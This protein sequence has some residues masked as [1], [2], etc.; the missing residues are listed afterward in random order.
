MNWYKKAQGNLRFENNHIDSHHRQNDYNLLAKINDKSVGM[1]EYSEY[2]DEIYVNYIIVSPQ[3][4]RQKIATKMMEELKRINVNMPVH[5][6]IMTDEGWKLK[7][8]LENK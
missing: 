1:I 2:N 6:G 3:L 5:W 4:R 8:S 7:Q